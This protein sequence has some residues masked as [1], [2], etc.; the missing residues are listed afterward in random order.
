MNVLVLNLTR[1]GD[2]LQSQPAVADLR[3]AGHRVGLV[4]LDNFAGAAGLL[5]G[6]DAVLPLAGARLLAGLDRD[7]RAAVLELRRFVDAV[8]ADFAPD[9]VVN[10]TPSAPARLLAMVLAGDPA[11]VRGFALDAEGFNADTSLWAAFLQLAAATRGASPFNI[12]DV[13]RRLPGLE[14]AVP[15]A[16][17][18]VGL[19][20]PAETELERVRARLR[21]LAPAPARGYVA[22]QLGASADARRWPVDHFVHV[23]RGLAAAGFTPVLVGAVGERELAA[24]FSA[25]GGGGVDL[26]GATTLP[27]LAAVLRAC[28]L[29]VTNDTGTMHLAAGLGVPCL[30]IFLATA[31]TWD[32]G[33]YLPG[34]LCL[35]PDMPCHPCG[36]G[37]AC[38]RDHACRR[39]IEPGGVLGLALLLLDGAATEMADQVDRVRAPGARAWRCEPGADGLLD[40]RSLTG[41]EGEDRTRLIRL[42][43]RLYLPYLDGVATA[44]ATAAGPGLSAEAAGP[45]LRALD[46][47]GGLLTL[48]RRQGEV[49]A[50]EPLPAMKAKFLAT[51]GRV[52]AALESEPRLA[53]AANLWFFEAERPGLDLP[54]ILALALRFAA[55]LAAM[56][57]AVAGEN[58]SGTK[59]AK[60][61]AAKESGNF[62][63][64][65]PP[66]EG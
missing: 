43:R 58:N 59:C 8:R 57:A 47:A 62:D 63:C 26:I 65:E 13:F 50:R 48:L 39:A 31:Q 20:G 49:L 46:E 23:A 3:A 34:C 56:R 25:A 6:L 52:R 41:H 10:L 37:E 29:L 11:R 21:D 7:W 30:A 32:T 33:P 35:E 22:V 17:V 40:L 61:L 38:P 54:G 2:L 24:R 28:S 66:K 14:S 64:Q 44:A 45:L 16:A 12:V 5:R 1:L 53:L 19:L 15:G 18:D 42:Q 60:Y 51:W 55:L 4:C 9:V 36:F 27:E